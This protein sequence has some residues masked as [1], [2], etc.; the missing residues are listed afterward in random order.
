LEGD[1]VK[2]VFIGVLAGVVAG[3]ASAAT[4]QVDFEASSFA[5][6]AG[7]VPAPFPGVQGHFEWVGI[8]DTAPI[9]ALTAV[10]LSIGDHTYTLA[11]LSFENG[12]G[13]TS[14]IGGLAGGG[15]NF[16]TAGTDDFVLT[17]DR[18]GQFYNFL[19]TVSG[20][21][22]A[23]VSQGTG[24]TVIAAVPEPESWLLCLLGIGALALRRLGVERSTVKVA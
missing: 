22:T 2:N 9:E 20:A 5:D 18:T 10:S 16:L 3:A 7:V 11:E 24:S 19:Y 8:D 21:N 1:T 23:W 14:S 13:T 15:S 6:V 17:F 4:Y 12:G